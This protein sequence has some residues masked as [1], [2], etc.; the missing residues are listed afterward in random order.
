MPQKWIIF[1]VCAVFQ[2][3]LFWA[4][5]ITFCEPLT[6]AANAAE[7]PASAE[8][9]FWAAMPLPDWRTRGKV[10]APRVALAKMARQRDLDEVNHY[11]QAAQPWAGAGSDW[12][13][14]R[15]DYDF[16][17]VSLT[18]LLY[19]FGNDPERLH[20]ETR[21]HLLRELLTETG[22]EPSL[23]APRSLGMVPETENHI[24]MTEGSRY[25]T[26]QWLHR[27]GPPAD[28]ENPRYDNAANGLATWL[29]DYLRELHDWGL[30][31]FNSRPYLGYTV[32]ALLNLEA[33][34]DDEEVAGQARA[35]LDGL[36]LRYSM[37]SL[38]LRRETP[39]RRQ[40]K[41]H[42]DSRL[43]GDPMTAYMSVWAGDTP[44]NRAA[45]P[46]NRHQRLI[47]ALLPYRPPAEI[48]QAVRQEAIKP[49]Y[50]RHGNRAHGSPEI[51]F[52]EP[53][54]LLSAGGVRPSPLLS[55]E[56]V[57][58]P[59]M[60]LLN[61]AAMDHDE[62]FHIAGRGRYSRWN[63]TGVFPR[64]AVGN[65]PVHIPPGMQAQTTCRG[66]LLFQP[67]ATDAPIVAVY[68][69]RDLG[70]IALFPQSQLNPDEL[71]EAIVRANP[72]P[73]TLKNRFNWP[74]GGSI[75]YQL[76]PSDRLWVI[77]AVDGQEVERDYRT[78]PSGFGSEIIGL[79]ANQFKSPK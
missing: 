10:H 77:T 61:D 48:L 71:I 27:H 40:S 36:A 31:E 29:A 68:N 23:S 21:E 45:P 63:Q 67:E 79:P 56:V 30:F 72:D 65:Q 3:F 18:T 12:A 28:R 47:A 54:Y 41:R 25:L 26:N 35:I 32:Q 39:F 22:G 50:M 1:P 19:L 11:L 7:D 20:T 44:V 38:N 15:G 60:L 13:G 46:A 51:Y 59:I 17:L 76:D 53:G 55:R 42:A 57:T 24:L 73:A 43:D 52:L 5:I 58:R 69:E 62:C 9:D 49:I 14:W 78:W 70:I 8:I 66:W 34:A 16:T 33:F 74:D 2:Y 64:F 6:T 75:D 4:G 37:S